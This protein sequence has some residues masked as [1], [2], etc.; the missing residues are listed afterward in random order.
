MRRIV[1]NIGLFRVSKRESRSEVSASLATMH[2]SAALTFSF[3]RWANKTS[4]QS[5]KEQEHIIHSISRNPQGRE[6]GGI[7]GIRQKESFGIEERRKVSQLSYFSRKGKRLSPNRSGSYDVLNLIM[8]I[9]H[10]H[11][12]R[13]EQWQVGNS[14]TTKLLPSQISPTKT[15]L[16]WLQKG[17]K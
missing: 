5:T 2:E 7:E 14:I 17:K 3:A 10:H 4:F 1:Y 15:A 8:L 9:G 13:R 11:H 12:S 6:K 16:I